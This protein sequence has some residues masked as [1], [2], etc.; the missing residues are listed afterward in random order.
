MR[1]FQNRE[2]TIIQGDTLEVLDK[3]V[4]DGSVNLIFADPLCGY[5]HNG[6]AMSTA[7]VRPKGLPFFSKIVDCIGREYL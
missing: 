1:K 2:T 6:S 7:H 3:T 5:P 4:S